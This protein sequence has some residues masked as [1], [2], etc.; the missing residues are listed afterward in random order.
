MNTYV[1]RY[2]CLHKR[3]VQKGHFV[4]EYTLYTLKWIFWTNI[5][6]RV[7]DYYFAKCMIVGWLGD[8]LGLMFFKIQ[9]IY[10]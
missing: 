2:G 9:S 6:V 10:C 3:W 7:K 5:I 1:D 8:T 4:V